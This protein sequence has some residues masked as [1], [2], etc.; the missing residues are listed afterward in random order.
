SPP[1][2]PSRS[3][4][5]SRKDQSD[6]SRCNNAPPA[7]PGAPS[8]DS[9]TSP[10]S[11]PTSTPPPNGD[12]INSASYTSS[13]PPAP[14]Y[15]QPSPQL[16]SYRRVGEPLPSGV[17]HDDC[18]RADRSPSRDAPNPGGLSAEIKVE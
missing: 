2:W 15:H 3:R 13:S 5:T 1:T 10:S 17:W 6:P 7:D 9:P 16:N 8:K 14:G 12:E 18:S 4:T 11:T